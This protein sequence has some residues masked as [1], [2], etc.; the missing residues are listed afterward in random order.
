[1]E[2]KQFLTGT[3][4]P[5]KSCEFHKQHN[6]YSNMEKDSQ[7]CGGLRRN[8]GINSASQDTSQHD[9]QYYLKEV[10]NTHQ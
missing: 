2:T 5:T 10:S 7:L 1:M 4:S 8:K 9:K 3:Y 6:I